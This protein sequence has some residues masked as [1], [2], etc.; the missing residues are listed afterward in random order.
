MCDA[1]ENP[2][3]A[4]ACRQ[5]ALA[6]FADRLN[7]ARDRRQFT[8]TDGAPTAPWPALVA[9]KPDAELDRAFASRGDL[10]TPLDRAPAR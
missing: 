8:C 2:M 9:W 6:L 7:Q 5:T 10:C 4:D 3:H 1:A